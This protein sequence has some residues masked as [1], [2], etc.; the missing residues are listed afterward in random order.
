MPLDP[1]FFSVKTHEIPFF[2][3]NSHEIQWNPHW[4]TM[5]S[6][7]CM[8][9]SHGNPQFSWFHHKNILQKFGPLALGRPGQEEAATKIQ[10]VERGRSARKAT[11]ESKTKGAGFRDFCGISAGFPLGFLWCFYGISMGFLWDFYDVSMGF[12]VDFWL[13]WWT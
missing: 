13:S 11:K 3:F 1:P 12:L 8:L 10:A 6:T 9:K 5:K 4:I 2:M 7:F